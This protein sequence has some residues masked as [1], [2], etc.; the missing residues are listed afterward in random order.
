M[1]TR[2][3]LARANAGE[4]LIGIGVPPSSPTLVEFAGFAG[5]DF[6][7]IDVHQGAIDLESCENMVRAAE[8]SGV[9]PIIRLYKNDPTLIPGF[10]DMGAAGVIVPHLNTAEQARAVAEQAR[11]RPN[12]RRGSNMA[13]RAARYGFVPSAREYQDQVNRDAIIIGMIEEK[14]AVNNLPA[15][16]DVPG[17]DMLMIGMMDLA[18][19]LGVAGQ[20]DHPTVQQAVDETI[21]QA[22]AAGR[23]VCVPTMELDKAAEW[24]TNLRQRGVHFTVV[25]VYQVLIPACKRLLAARG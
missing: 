25:S 17:I 13:A 6:V 22:R 2:S 21:R 15:I 24:V 8:V 7:F 4:S 1:T 19:S 18:E 5:F 3:L 16:L 20:W 12:G 14:Q 10:M 23:H 9:A 11:F